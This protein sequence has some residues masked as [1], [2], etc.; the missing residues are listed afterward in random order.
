MAAELGDAVRIVKVDT[1]A[2]PELSSQ[3]QVRTKRGALFCPT[4]PTQL[5]AVPRPRAPLRPRFKAFRRSSSSPRRKTRLRWC[6][7]RARAACRRGL[8]PDPLFAPLQRAE[9]LL[10]ASTVMKIIKD[11]C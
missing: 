7:P 11:E 5:F 2:E 8:Y 10:P 1:E 3:L 6:A 4:Q 9:G